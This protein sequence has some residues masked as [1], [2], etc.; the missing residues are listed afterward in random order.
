MSRSSIGAR[1]AS[2][3]GATL[4]IAGLFAQ[5]APALA[6]GPGPRVS[7]AWS[8][9]STAVHQGTTT[10]AKLSTL[11]ARGSSKLPFDPKAVGKVL[12]SVESAA[13]A[14][15]KAP[16]GVKPNVPPPAPDPATASGKAAATKPV[17]V[18]GLTGGGSGSTIGSDSGVAVG[19]DEVVQTVNTSLSIFDRS[20]SSLAG[21]PTI[22][23]PAFFSLTETG[24]SGHTTF[25]AEPRVLFDTVRQRWIAIE[26]SWD[27]SRYKVNP[28]DALPAFGHGFL[29][30]G[31]SDTADPTG[32]WTTSSFYWS[33]FVPDRPSVGSTTD[34]LA[35][36]A[37]L[38]EMGPGGSDTTPGCISAT[39]D[40]SE[41]IAVDWSELGPDFDSPA[42][43]AAGSYPELD[44]L[45]IAS[46][47]PIVDADVRMIGLANGSVAGQGAGDVIYVDISG[48]T[49]S[50][51]AGEAR[52]SDLT[53]DGI[54]PPFVAPPSPAQP[55]TTLTAAINGAPDSVVY[56]N[57]VLAFAAT[58]PCTPTGDSSTRDCVRV[59][60]LANPVAASEPTRQADVLLATD[61]LD[62]SFG[63]L[64]FTG[65]GVL[66]A[67][68]TQSSGTLDPTSATQYQAP[69]DAATAWS[70]PAT[71]TAGA[72][73]YGGT[74]WGAA[75]IVA[76]DPQDPN[77]AWVG[78]PA[79]AADGTWATTIHELVVGGAGA[80]YFP[81]APVRVLDSRSSGGSPVGFSG[82]LTANVPRTFTVA[83]SHGIPPAAIAI[84]ANLS[85]TGQTKAG[86]LALTPTPTASPSSATLNFPTADTR[87]NNTTIALA[88]DGSLAVV[89]KAP[90]GAHT[91]VILDVTGYFATSGSG[92]QRY[93]PLAGPVRILDTRAGTALGQ[94][95]FSANVPKTFHVV[96]DTIIP[97]GASAITANLAVVNQTK[98]GYVT[99]SPTPNA[100]P[101]TS[102]I[103]FPTGD[104]RANGLTIPVNPLDGTVAA[105]YKA[106][107]GT[108]DLVL[109]VTGYYSADVSGLLFHPLNPG[110]RVDTRL[111]A[112]TDGLG[113]GLSGAQGTT[114]RSVVV[115]G[116]DGL[117]AAAAAITG[118]LSVTAQTA[119]GYV[120]ITTTSVLHPTTSTINFPLGDTRGNGIT[121]PLGT[122][123]DAGKLWFVYQ[124]GSTK[125]VQLILDI[126]GY[127]E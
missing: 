7:S 82:V 6:A 91:N 112:G 11:A 105:V 39:Q 121:V 73:A 69:G 58:Y 78:D 14:A 118:N 116:H 114:P 51:T 10:S 18:A 26:L 31:I 86:Y 28:G 90:S 47:E 53:A 97:S 113:N 2:V 33:D 52:Y 83:G 36:S 109:D 50:G 80:G 17:A 117:P 27:C 56:D 75:P 12:Q 68:Y 87:G 92:G 101:T 100:S 127:F 81:L 107:S 61:G 96:D 45:R 48:S 94:T 59:T 66:H 42:H 35:L 88:P 104:V 71:L 120:A 126:T 65:S 4:L 1:F 32:F 8:G 67:V 119:A 63:G 20:G 122:G 34:K 102:T 55:G 43:F 9:S 19:P 76:T 124:L 30:Y 95:T 29:D 5:A 24:G 16:A 60:R 84:T 46:E 89:Y 62:S 22:T 74:A 72:A 115:A 37:G 70:A 40:G 57:H 99:L 41:A 15:G 49:V 54:I 38:F 110:R 64:G 79:A 44:A 123:G 125:H 98:A 93:S 106:P 103:N 13:G 108:V 21:V 85:V 3:G 111:A 23:L 77:A 25:D